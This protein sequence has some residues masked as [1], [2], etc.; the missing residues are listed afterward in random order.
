MTGDQEER[1]D[2]LGTEPGADLRVATFMLGETTDTEIDRSRQHER[3]QLAAS[4]LLERHLRKQFLEPETL[5]EP[6]WEILVSA[7]LADANGQARTVVDASTV[8]A[9]P[10]LSGF[11]WFKLLEKLGLVERRGGVDGEAATAGLTVAG[12]NAIESYLD[13]LALQRGLD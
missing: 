3:I 6:A 13:A 4:I 9:N 12:R 10:F 11:R 1:T 5:G 7:Y 8:C 2:A